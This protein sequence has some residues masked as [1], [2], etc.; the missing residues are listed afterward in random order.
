MAIRDLSG[1][2]SRTPSGRPRG[3]RAADL[4]AAKTELAVSAGL[5]AG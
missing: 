2:P 5:L 1:A 3:P 4:L